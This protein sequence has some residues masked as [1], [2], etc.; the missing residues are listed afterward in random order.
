MEIKQLTRVVTQSRGTLSCT[1]TA[2]RLREIGTDS[3]VLFM[4][5]QQLRE[6]L[7]REVVEEMVTVEGCKI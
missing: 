4:E 7:L 2:G 5:A 3:Q 1:Y 6:C